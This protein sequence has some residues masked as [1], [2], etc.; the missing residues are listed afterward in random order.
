LRA[1]VLQLSG[2][3]APVEDGPQ[4]IILRNIGCKPLKLHAELLAEGA[5]RQPGAVSWHEIALY[6]TE[7][8]Q[9]AVALRLLRPLP[10]DL[11]VHRA[12][13]FE[14]L[15]AAS[16]WLE[17]FDTSVDVE[18]DFDVADRGLSTA[19]MTM[20]AAALR[21]R[22]ERLDRGYRCLVGEILFRLAVGR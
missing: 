1:R 6:R 7:A 19:S 18:A 14:D 15:D 2:V 20:Q 10:G 17:Q 5:S 8:G 12:R 13:L 22:A 4:P 16:D 9:I 3:N 21:E 11:G